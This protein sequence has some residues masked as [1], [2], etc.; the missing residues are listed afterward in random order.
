[1]KLKKLTTISISVVFIALFV[2]TNSNAY[3]S[4]DIYRIPQNVDPGDI[5]TIYAS[6]D[7]DMSE[8]IEVGTCLEY[9]L[10]GV[11]QPILEPDQTIPSQ[12]QTLSWI[13]GSFEQDDYVE[14]KIYLV[15]LYEEEYESDWM[16]F[17]E[18]PS[19]T[20]TTTDPPEPPKIRTPLTDEQILYICVGSVAGFAV[21][22]LI[23][24]QIR[25]RR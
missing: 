21:G 22:V 11:M 12:M 1:M 23:L 16:S 19:T 17:G 8:E 10:N 6:I 18:E 4:V 14:Y 2:S 15:F 24:F 20:T 3:Y 5:V 7:A 9:K 13:L 25:K